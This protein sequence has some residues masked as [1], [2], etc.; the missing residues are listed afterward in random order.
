MRGELEV[1]LEPQRPTI[2]TNNRH[3]RDITADALKALEQANN[4]PSLFT[5]GTVP[6]RVDASAKAEALTATSLKGI[7]DRTADFVKVKTKQGGDGE[8]IRE[9]SPVRPPS[10]LAPDILALDC[11]PLPRLNAIAAA[12]VALPDGTLLLQDG[13]NAPHGILLRSKGLEQLRADILIYPPLRRWRYLWTCSA[14]FPLPNQKQDGRTF[15][16]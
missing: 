7:L 11:L 1:K 15:L 10:D 13:F 8:P 6:V 14:T 4:P 9:E 2:Q 5:R 3:L 12:P 16:P